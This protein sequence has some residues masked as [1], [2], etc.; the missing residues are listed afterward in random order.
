MCIEMTIEDTTTLIFAC[1]F[2]MLEVN[3]LHQTFWCKKAGPKNL[4]KYVGR[5]IRERFRRENWNERQIRKW[6]KR[7]N[8]KS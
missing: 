4:R 5:E 8:I 7:E 3:A 6:I 2:T 1:I